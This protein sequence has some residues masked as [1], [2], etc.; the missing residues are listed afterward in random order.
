MPSL[1][2]PVSV[3][4]NAK[5]GLAWRKQYNR[6]G[7][8]VGVARARDLSNRKE[9]SLSTIKRMKAYFDRHSVDKQSKKWNDP[10]AG[11]IAWYLWGGDAGYTWAKSI[12]SKETK[13]QKV[14]ASGASYDLFRRLVADNSTKINTDGASY[15]LYRKLA[16]LSRKPKTESA[17]LDL[18]KRLQSQSKYPETTMVEDPDYGL[19]EEIRLHNKAVRARQVKSN[20][21]T[22]R[23][24]TT[25]E[26]N[27]LKS[28]DFVFP[29]KREYPI[30][31][32]EHARIALAFATKSKNPLIKRKVF[33]AVYKRYPELRNPD[34]KLAKVV[35]KFAMK[36]E[37]L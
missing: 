18:A 10:S 8:S 24:L 9:L 27:E 36:R 25:K 37:T 15:K 3:A 2:P 22:A 6:G 1:V 7:T 14:Q 29:K 19:P 21:I 26:R 33:N 30:Q 34:S 32:I 31:D 4:N 23:K 28:S 11:K 12:L 16:D 20:S 17:S 5:K 13:M 35:K